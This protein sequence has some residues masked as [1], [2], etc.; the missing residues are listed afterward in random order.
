MTRRTRKTSLKK[1]YRGRSKSVFKIAIQ[2]VEKAL[3]QAY[4]D[5]KA[6]LQFK[7]ER[8]TWPLPCVCEMCFPCCLQRCCRGTNGDVRIVVVLMPTPRAPGELRWPVCPVSPCEG[9]QPSSIR[10][11]SAW[12]RAA[13]TLLLASAFNVLGVTF[14]FTFTSPFY[15]LIFTSG[16][17]LRPLRQNK[18]R[19]F[20]RLWIERI[21]AGVRQH[22]MPYSVF[23]NK[24]QKA[25]VELNRKVCLFFR[26]VL[27]G[28]EGVRARTCGAVCVPK[29]WRVYPSVSLD[30]ASLF[31]VFLLALRFGVGA[32]HVAVRVFPTGSA[33]HLWF[34][35]YDLPPPRAV[36]VRFPRG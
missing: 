9:A 11:A 26:R 12:K 19:D 14:A 4:R 29:R 15:Q 5:R 36:D 7:A 32:L 34:F 22:G 30:P 33:C 18:K 28:G 24:A 8:P 17:F 31:C 13:D 2:K 35:F 3:Q 20:R 25:D 23:V 1:R 16:V 10:G 6:R 27:V 21:N